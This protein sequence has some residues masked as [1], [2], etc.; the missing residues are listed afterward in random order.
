LYLKSREEDIGNFFFKEE[1]RILSSPEF[2]Q[3]YF[4]EKSYCCALSI[5]PNLSL[6]ELQEMIYQYINYGRSK[7]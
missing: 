4:F 5:A 2:D 6:I 1:Q 7:K 3:G